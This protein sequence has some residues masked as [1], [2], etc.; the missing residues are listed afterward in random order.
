M[1]LKVK[2]WLFRIYVKFI[3]PHT[4]HF[5]NKRFEKGF[6]DVSK[7]A[8]DKVKNLDLHEFALA[9]DEF[10]YKKDLLGGL[11]DH[12]FSFDKPEMFFIQRVYNRDC[13]NYARLASIYAIENDYHFQEVIVT[14]KDHVAKDAHVVTVLW[15]DNEYYLFDYDVYGPFHSFKEAVYEIPNHWK[16]YTEDN[17]VYELYYG[18][19]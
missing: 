15:K 1:K 9:L 14:T 8:W 12:S 3:R 5:L 16:K 4:E 11:I 7:N 17:M 10:P 19:R 6:E 13:D 2:L 18:V